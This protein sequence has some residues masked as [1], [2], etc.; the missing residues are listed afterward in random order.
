MRYCG[1]MFISLVNLPLFSSESIRDGQFIQC[2]RDLDDVIITNMKKEEQ[3]KV[4]QRGIAYVMPTRSPFGVYEEHEWGRIEDFFSLPKIF[5][6][7]FTNN[8][9][10]LR[11]SRNVY[12]EQVHSTLTGKGCDASDRLEKL[13]NFVK[14]YA[15]ILRCDSNRQQ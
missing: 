10:R 11:Q 4:H 12:I 2:L 13:G 7:A 6:Y 15:D 3:Q 14:L 8:N 1:L 9:E 5:A